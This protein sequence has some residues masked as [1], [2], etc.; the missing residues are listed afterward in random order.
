MKNKPVRRDLP[1]YYVMKVEVCPTCHG[2]TKTQNPLYAEFDKFL[3]ENKTA[4]ERV[5]EEQEDQWWTTQGY[6]NF[7]WPQEEF[8]CEECLRTGYIE[9]QIPMRQA[10]QEVALQ[11][12]KIGLCPAD[13]SDAEC[14]C[15]YH[16]KKAGHG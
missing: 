7:D 4:G 2:E 12:G 14:E 3:D 8:P 9:S 10:L 11:I 16:K 15:G 5:S 6:P 1:E 13:I